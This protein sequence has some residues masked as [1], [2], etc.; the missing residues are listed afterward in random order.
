MTGSV[1]RYNVVRIS[2]IVLG[3]LFAVGTVSALHGLWGTKRHMQLV[4]SQGSCA[5][6][7]LCDAP[8]AIAEA[9]KY[10]PANRNPHGAVARLLFYQT[11]LEWGGASLID[12]DQTVANVDENLT[13]P[14]W[15]VGILGDCVT[16]NDFAPSPSTVQEPVEGMWF[17][18]MASGRGLT[19]LGGLNDSTSSTGFMTI[20]SIH[21]LPS[22]NLPIHPPTP[23]PTTTPGPTPTNSP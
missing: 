22:A 21:S 19:S 11:A 20:N 16:V 8:S 4:S 9:L 2:T 13:R 10:F 6:D 15:L 3:C 12:P 14:V 5:T 18:L 7:V 17:M 1:R 23:F